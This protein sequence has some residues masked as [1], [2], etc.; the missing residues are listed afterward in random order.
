MTASPSSGPLEVADASRPTV[1]A[2][3]LVEV[4]VTHEVVVIDGR[5]A[6]AHC[7]CGWRSAGRRNR[8][9]VR[10]EA[11]DHVLLYVDGRSAG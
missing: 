3:S 1:V 10:A 4:P 2:S 5:F 8:A 7:T 11:R 6:A 9:T